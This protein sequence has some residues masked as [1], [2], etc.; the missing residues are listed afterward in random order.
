MEIIPVSRDHLTFVL[1]L[2]QEISPFLPE[3]S[4][5]DEVWSRFASQ[6][7]IVA[8][9]AVE[10]T[11]VVG[12]G[13]SLIESKIRGGKLAHIED[14][15]SHPGSRGQG[16]GRAIVQ[17]LVERAISDGCYKVVLNC[18]EHNQLFYEKCGF[19]ASG[20]SMQLLTEGF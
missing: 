3:K 16:I 13:V 6:P 7:N 14:I 2:L 10:G 9:V 15:V 8:V 4:T 5:Y 19:K 12:Y 11:Q 18:S 1:S 20:S 17:H